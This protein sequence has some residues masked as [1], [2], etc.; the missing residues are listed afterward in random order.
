[1]KHG[2]PCV[3][4]LEYTPFYNYPICIAQDGKDFQMGRIVKTDELIAQM[5]QPIF[6]HP[7]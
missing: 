6:L 4:R 5:M 2:C 1:M 3:S 7:L